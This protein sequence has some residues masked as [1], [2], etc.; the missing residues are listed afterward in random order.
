VQGLCAGAAG[1]VDFFLPEV[2]WVYDAMF[3]ALVLAAFVLPPRRLLAAWKKRS[4]NWSG[5]GCRP[6]RFT[7]VELAIC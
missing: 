3:T 4:R 6:Q 5:R 1:E 2:S 7:V